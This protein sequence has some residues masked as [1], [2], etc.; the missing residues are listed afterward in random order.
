[1]PLKKYL[2]AGIRPTIE[3]DTGEKGTGE[4]LW[5]I[6]KAITRK[7]DGSSRVWG[8]DQAV[9]RQDALR[10]KTIWPAA[11]TGDESELGSLEP[12]K[13]ADV[14]VLDRDYLTVPEEEIS[15]LKV[16]MTMVG[17]KIVYQD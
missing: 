1:M 10:M 7:V 6:E 11:Y 15:E 5:T 14:V 3:A 17:G 8:A 9:T 13:L 4:P 2:D 12:G 16:V